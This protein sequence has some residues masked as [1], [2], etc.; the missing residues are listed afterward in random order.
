MSHPSWVR[1]LKYR[2]AY[3]KEGL[4]WVAPFVGA[5]IEIILAHM[6]SNWKLHVAPFVGAW[7]E[8]ST[9]RRKPRTSLSRTLRGCV[10]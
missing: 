8:I 5:W 2:L 9:W 6:G 1:G 10:D 4:R 7:I 3:F